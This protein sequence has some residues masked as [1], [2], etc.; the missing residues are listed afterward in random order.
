MTPPANDHAPTEPGRLT[1]F[2]V[3]AFMPLF[4]SSN[5]VIGRAAAELVPP[6]SLAFWRWLIAFLIL[7]PFTAMA[8]RRDFQ[9]F[10][11][12]RAWIALLS[13]LGMGIC[14]AGVYIALQHTTA[15]NGALIYTAT[16]V[17]VILFE[18]AFAGNRL[19]LTRLF[20][21]FIAIGGVCVVIFKGD[22]SRLLSLELN[23][24]DLLMALA[25]TSW[26]GYTLILKRPALRAMPTLPLM[27]AI[28]LGGAILLFPFAVWEYVTVGGVPPVLPAWASIGG[29]AL[30]ASVLAFS[31]YQYGVR[32]VGPG[33]TSVFLYMVPMHAALLASLF[34]GEALAAYH[35]LGA[36][37]IIGGV[38]LATGIAGSMAAWA[39]R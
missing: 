22:L 35:L 27:A 30:F 16:P 37:C 7:L 8:L 21:V 38:S 5:I 29:V 19:T 15:T 20:G 10:W 17:I 28:T 32:H 13:F 9:A 11:A 36:A 6:S 3:L 25:A 12:Q 14:G 1:V 26:A 4:F 33:V 34:L 18:W 39:R 2:A 31:A 24:G 23:I